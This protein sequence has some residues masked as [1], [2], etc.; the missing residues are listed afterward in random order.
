MRSSPEAVALPPVVRPRARVVGALLEGWRRVLHAPAVTAGVWLLTLA[1]AAPLA[2]VVGDQI[3]THLGSSLE[4]EQMLSGWPARWEGEFSATAQGAAQTFTHEILGF[5]G[6]LATWSRFAD[7][8]PL[9]RSLVGALCLYLLLW[10]FLS[11]GI[12]D[13]MARGRR[14]RVSAFF[15]ACGVYFFR[16]VRLGIVIGAAHWASF[17][18][19]HPLLFGAVYD[20]LTQD[21]AT[22]HQAIVYRTGLYAVFFACLILVSTIA[23]F[24]KV[25][26]VVEDRHSA[27]AALGASIRFVRRR[28]LRV[29]GLYLLNVLVF[30]VIA[31]LWLQLAPTASSS[32]WGALLIAQVFLLARIWAKLAFMASEVV[33]FQGELAHATYTAAPEPSWPDSAGVEAIG[34]LKR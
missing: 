22:E 5:G 19:L 28:P 34:N 20:R 15:A 1:V 16:F 3:E 24:A 26:A 9:P 31:R 6:T 8:T 32:T 29:L 11:G 14:V 23:D 2:M 30:L 33:F 18:W 4:A 12:L 21:V 7:A 27:V 17:R 25:R 10:L 13:R